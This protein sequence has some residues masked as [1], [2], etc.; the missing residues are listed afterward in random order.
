[1]WE[2]ESRYNFCY[3]S[4]CVLTLAMKKLGFLENMEFRHSNE[5]KS[6]VAAVKMTFGDIYNI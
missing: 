4:N 6:V 3:M 2:I 1:M 5:R